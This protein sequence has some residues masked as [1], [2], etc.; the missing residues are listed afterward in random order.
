MDIKE[1]IA[2]VTL[3]PALA[4][5]VNAFIKIYKLYQ[6]HEKEIKEK[7]KETTEDLKEKAKEISEKITTPPQS[8]PQNPNDKQDE[9]LY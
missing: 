7:V 4:W 5:F 3:V 2:F 6:T 1:L 8:T 9:Q